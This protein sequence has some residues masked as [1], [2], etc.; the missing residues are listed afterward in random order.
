[1]WF[2]LFQYL[3]D[4]NGLELN[5]QYLLSMLNSVSKCSSQILVKKLQFHVIIINLY[6]VFR[7]MKKMW[8]NVTKM[9]RWKDAD[10]SYS[11]GHNTYKAT[12]INSLTEIQEQ[13]TPTHWATEKIPTLK[14]IDKTKTHSHHKF[15]SHLTF[16]LQFSLRSKS[17]SV[18]NTYLVPQ[19]F[20]LKSLSSERQ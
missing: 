12:Q 13:V 19:D 4:W 17:S 15:H 10:S 9:M 18:W 8:P 6:E 1:M 2:T 7:V 20:R 14:W 3:L 11:S 16:L 5:P